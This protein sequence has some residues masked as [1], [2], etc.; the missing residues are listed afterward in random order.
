MCLGNDAG[1][2]FGLRKITKPAQRQVAFALEEEQL[3]LVVV[4]QD[5][6]TVYDSV[7]LSSFSEPVLFEGVATL[8]NRH[9]LAG[10]QCTLVISEHHYQLLLIDK[11]PV[12]AGELRQALKWKTKGLVNYSTDDVAID[13]FSV[14]PHGTGGQRQKIFVVAASL[15]FLSVCQKAFEKALLSLTKIDIGLMAIRNMVVLGT[16]PRATK[17]C[18]SAEAGHCL[19]SIFY[20]GDIYLARKLTVG[21]ITHDNFQNPSVV[22]QLL[23]E[24]ERSVAYLVAELK[25]GEVEE[26]LLSPSFLSFE[27]LIN[28][29]TN[30]L[31]FKVHCLNMNEYVVN[32]R[33]LSYQLQRQ[34]YHCLGS[35]VENQIGA[36]LGK[37][38]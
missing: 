17:L 3:N 18:L 14:P 13:Y 24:I 5:V 23:V 34:Y 21:E 11:L 25:L 32:E 20:N 10:S 1:A 28:L 12:E 37:V 27:K 7:V 26:L 4:E 31:P 15:S 2:M 22:E 29:L 8:V 35:I 16:T 6:L 9:G 30:Q 38:A 33:P 19:L 36:K